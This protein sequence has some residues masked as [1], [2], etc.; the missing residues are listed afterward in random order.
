MEVQVP[1]TITSWVA[2]GFAMSSVYGMGVSNRATLKAFQPFFLQM[3]LP[4]SVIRGE[5]VPITVTVFNYL[6]S[7]VPVSVQL[8]AKSLNTIQKVLRD[9]AIKINFVL[10]ER[11]F[12]VIYEDPLQLFRTLLGFR[13]ILTKNSVQSAILVL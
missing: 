8:L 1:D 13:N 12:K 10:F 6:S 3:T 9:M 5:E 2:N 4:Y 11:T 7:C